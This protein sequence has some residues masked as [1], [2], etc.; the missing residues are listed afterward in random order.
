MSFAQVSCTVVIPCFN[1]AQRLCQDEVL[2]L[3]RARGV[4]VLLVDDGSTD[5][6]LQVLR[7][8]SAEPN[9]DH[10][11]L[12]ANGGKA[13]AV[14][15]G[16]LAALD[17]DVSIVG[18]IDADFAVPSLEVLRLL[19][20]LQC[21]QQLEA[22]LGSRVS[23]AGRRIERPRL[24]HYIGRTLATY[25]ASTYGLPIYDTQCGAKF[26]RCGPKLRSAL[27]APFVTRWLFDVE[28]LVR[29]ARADGGPIAAIVREEPLEQWTHVGDS[30]LAGTEVR[31]VLADFWALRRHVPTLEPA[32][33]SCSRADGAQEGPPVIS[34]DGGSA[35]E[36]A[37]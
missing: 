12:G 19:A 31:R 14:R 4:R 7:T 32:A 9:I 33:M 27:T 34:R 2:R 30:R 6:T 24:R 35:Y 13:E 17:S 26:F 16:M 8:L 3:S 23:L 28:L 5:D 1:E 37:A 11:R 25:L 15:A 22:L 20:R 21:D 18:Y 36:I 10:L 29:M